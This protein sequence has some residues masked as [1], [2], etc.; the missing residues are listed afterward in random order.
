MAKSKN[1]TAHNQ[2]IQLAQSF[3]VYCTSDFFI[4]D[5]CPVMAYRC[6]VVTAILLML[7]DNARAVRQA[8]FSVVQGQSMTEEGLDMDLDTESDSESELG[9]QCAKDMYGVKVGAANLAGC[10]KRNDIV[11]QRSYGT[12]ADDQVCYYVAD[13][14]RYVIETPEKGVKLKYGPDGLPAGREVA[15]FMGIRV[16]PCAAKGSP[17]ILVKDQG[18]TWFRLRDCGRFCQCEAPGRNVMEWGRL[19]SAQFKEPNT[20]VPGIVATP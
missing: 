12:C 11:A 17:V 5:Q 7:I 3:V 6:G 19:L 15:K 16:S 10:K 13:V 2:S 8:A 14:I 9:D 18:Q 20:A 1:H 4:A